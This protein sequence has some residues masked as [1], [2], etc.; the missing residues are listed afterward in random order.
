[1]KLSRLAILAL[2]LA[3]MLFPRSA[4]ANTPLVVQAAGQ[5]VNNASIYITAYTFHLL[6]VT[7][8]NT[9][10]WTT[11]YVGT[12]TI[13]TQTETF[14]CPAGSQVTSAGETAQKC[15][16]VLASGH[17]DFQLT[18]HT[19]GGV[20]PQLVGGTLIE[21]AGLGAED[22]GARG[23]TA[24]AT[25]LSTTTANAN[26]W[27]DVSCSAYANNISPASGFTTTMWV[28]AQ[29]VSSNENRIWSGYHI[30]AGAGTSTSTCTFTSNVDKHVLVLAFQQSSP[31]AAPAVRILQPC[32]YTAGAN[33]T[34][35][36]CR[37]YDTISGSK[38]ILGYIA[39]ANSGLT[40]LT[41]TATET[42]TCHES[43]DAVYGGQSYKIGICW[44]DNTTTHSTFT[45]TISYGGPA[46]FQN[47]SLFGME[48]SGLATGEDASSFS[49]AAATSLTYTTASS[50]EWTVMFAADDFNSSNAI[51]AGDSFIQVNTNTRDA[52]T[53]VNYQTMNY[54]TTASSGSGKPAS[55][56]QT[57]SASPMLA[58]LSFGPSVLPSVPRHK[59]QVF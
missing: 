18:Y 17:S 16:V 39:V 41:C 52:Y 1:M 30:V 55:Y 33:T 28:T 20:G 34:G 11:A 47:A 59:G 45:I 13:D 5:E 32:I 23:A 53:H 51:V 31:P 43:S 48:V 22:T 36:D 24:S 3:G 21:V 8:G 54:K 38:V 58:V 15:F 4:S 56:T 12:L 2:F 57:G 14:T 44:V 10:I 9:L 50:S 7:S 26:E 37:L 40:S 49:S 42:C 25:S 6:N 35:A 29:N 19:S 27:V 46:S